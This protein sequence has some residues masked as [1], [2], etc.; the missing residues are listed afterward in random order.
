MGMHANPDLAFPL[1]GRDITVSDVDQPGDIGGA[2]HYPSRDFRHPARQGAS[3]GGTP[4]TAT[5]QQDL[6]HKRVDLYLRGVAEQ[7]ASGLPTDVLV[8][9]ELLGPGGGVWTLHTKKDGPKISEGR[10]LWADSILTCTLPRFVDI[11]TGRIDVQQAFM[12]GT[13][14]VEGDVGLLLRLHKALP[15][16]V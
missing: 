3:D 7:V 15:E 10:A 13:V 4:M 8:T 14:R 5:M 2:G 16:A 6:G 11:V 12:D 9:F 1:L